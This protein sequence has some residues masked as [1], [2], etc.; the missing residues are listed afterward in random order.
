A[1]PPADRSAD[2]SA[3]LPGARTS[4][5]PLRAEDPQPGGAPVERPLLP[6]CLVVM[7]VFVG[8]ATVANWSAKYLGDVLGSSEQLATVP[9]S[10]YTVAALL[11]RAVGDPA[12]RRFGPVAVVRAGVLLAVVGFAVVASAPGPWAGL[13]GFTLLGPALGVIVPQA[14]AA[15]AR[16]RPAASE[17]AVARLNVF[18]YA[19]FL[20]GSPLVGAV[21]EA[22]SHRGAMLV[23]TV[24]LLATLPRIRSFGGVPARYG[25]VHERPR[26]TD[27]GRGS[28]RL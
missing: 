25:D 18:N 11:G 5:G 9:Y 2:P 10:A 21:G 4:A 13:L 23:P 12:V 22:W 3:G 28:D 7:V 8:D 14:F 19:G 1:G 16:L 6:L 27:V 24:L 26:A 20:V 15:A 17:T